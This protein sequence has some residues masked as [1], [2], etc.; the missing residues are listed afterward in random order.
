MLDRDAMQLHRLMSIAAAFADAAAFK[1]SRITGV[2]QYV[3]SMRGHGPIARQADP[4]TGF[5]LT[6]CQPHR[7]CQPLRLGM[8]GFSIVHKTS[9]SSGVNTRT[10]IVSIAE[11]F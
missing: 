3:P 11:R 8:T 1:A 4:P 10:S 6:A 7:L 9:R 2:A 5:D